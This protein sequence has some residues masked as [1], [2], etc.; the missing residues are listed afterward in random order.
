MIER[1]RNIEILC[2]RIAPPKPPWLIQALRSLSVSHAPSQKS[3]SFRDWPWNNELATNPSRPAPF[4]HVPRCALT[5]F[6]G[7]VNVLIDLFGLELRSL[8][9]DLVLLFAGKGKSDQLP[10]DR[11]KCTRVTLGRFRPR[12]LESLNAK[13]ITTGDRPSFSRDPSH[14][15][16][17]RRSRHRKSLQTR[18]F[19]G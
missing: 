6:R 5:D 17:L 15:C 11:I 18:R 3:Q 13:W 19:V 2:L 12:S 10:R 16:R 9:P 1:L 4:R 14:C 8:R 7:A